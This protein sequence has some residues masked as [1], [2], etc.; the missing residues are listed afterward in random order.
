ME[1]TR[2][3][4]GTAIFLGLVNYYRRF[5]RNFAKIAKPLTDLTKK[6]PFIWTESTHDTFLALKNAVITAPVI[7][8]FSPDKP[9]FITTDASKDAIGAVMEQEFED[10]KHPVCFASRVLNSAEQNYA[11]HDLELLVLLTQSELGD[12]TYMVENLQYSRITIHCG[13]WKHKSIF[14]QDKSDGLRDLRN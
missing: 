7:H 5:I 4:K 12:T 11:A 14:H 8:Q 1:V 6:V 10:G 2:V 3:K 13:I 9:I